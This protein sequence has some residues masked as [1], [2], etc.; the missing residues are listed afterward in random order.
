[1]DRI[2]SVKKEIFRGIIRSNFV[3][4]MHNFFRF[5]I[6]AYFR[7]HYQSMFTHIPIGSGVRMFRLS[8]ENVSVSNHSTTAPH[9]IIYSPGRIKSN[10][11]P[12]FSRKFFPKM[13]L[14]YFNFNGFFEFLSRMGYRYFNFRF[15]GLSEILSIYMA[16]FRRTTFNSLDI[17]RINF[18]SFIANA[19]FD[20]HISNIHYIN[21]DSNV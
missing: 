16:T 7:F 10:F 18:D 14:R 13:R 17:A 2:G 9:M 8:Y 11:L 4:M 20:K 19:A 3:S 15:W 5:Q 1:M 12:G 6:T 21:G